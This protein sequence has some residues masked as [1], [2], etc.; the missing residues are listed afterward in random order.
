MIYCFDTS[1]INRLLDDPE[2]E[3]IVTTILS[4]GSFRITAYNVLEA[5]KTSDLSRRTQ[6]LKLMCRLAN[7]NRPL[8]RPNRILSKYLDAHAAGTSSWKINADAK[9]DGTWLALNQP[10]CLDQN[11]IDEVVD[12]AN[13]SEQDFSSVV[14]GDRVKFQSVFNQIPTSEQLKSTASTLRV[15][16]TNKNFLNSLVSEAYERQTGKRLIDPEIES[17]VQEPVCGLYFLAYAYA[18]HHRAMQGQGYSANRNAGAIDLWQAVYLSLCDR[19][20]TN[21]KAQYRGLRLLNVINNNLHTQVM[22][23]DTFRSR[24]LALP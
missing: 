6:L 7:R 23:Y 5:A 22:R 15:F 8:D 13:K 3:P 9:L 11:A 21:D 10:D 24:L 19:Y 2:R 14:A 1:A 17:L 4:I 16:S 12:W 20:V 18:L